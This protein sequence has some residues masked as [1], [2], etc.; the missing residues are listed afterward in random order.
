[1]LLGLATTSGGRSFAAD[2]DSLNLVTFAESSS[3]TTIGTAV[4][5]PFKDESVSTSGKA[6]STEP[7]VATDSPSYSAGITTGCDNFVGT[8]GKIWF[9]GEYLHWWTSGAHLPPMVSTLTGPQGDVPETLFGD[10]TIYNGNHDGY[11]VAFG[12]WLDCQHR[13]GV[14]ADYFDLSGKQGNYD[15]GFTDGYAN[16]NAYPIIR[17]AYDPATYSLPYPNGGLAVDAVGY[18]GYY[19]GRI[20]VETSNYFQSAGITLRR[21]LRASEWSTCNS[22]VNWTDS[23]ARTFRLDA[24]GGYRFARLIDAVNE[25]DDSFAFWD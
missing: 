19:N 3:T 9:R 8:P 15:S 7:A 25:Q 18:P 11:R 20:T 17:L 24:I 14:E 22:D 2:I 10:Q 23:P 1:M 16:G 13:C 5:N 12:M 21:Q 4:A 6:V